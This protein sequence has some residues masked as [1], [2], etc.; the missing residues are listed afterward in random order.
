MDREISL[1]EMLDARERR[2]LR[3]RQL[4][5]AHRL[6][7]VSFTMN[8]A[9]PVKNGPVL[10]R[11]FREGLRRLEDALR[12]RRM[13]LSH[14]ELL[15]R[16]TGCEALLVVE[17]DAVSLKRLCAALEDRDALGRLFDIDVLGPDGEKL[18]RESLGFAPRPCLVCGREGKACASRRLHSLE[19]LQEK[20]GAILR[21]FFARKD[22]ETLAAQALRALLY[23]VCAA[24]KPA[25]VDRLNNGSHRDMDLFSFL[26][27]AASLLPY[28]RTAASLGMETAALSPEESFLRLREEGL[29][30]ERAMLAATGG[31][32]THKGAV[33]TLGTV[34]CAAGRLWKPERPWAET[35]A[36]LREAG[37]MSAR[38]A[39]LDL[40]APQA[41]EAET[42]GR[43][44]FRE[45]GIRGVR[46]ELAG[47]LPSVREIGLPAL[48]AALEAGAS[49]EQAGLAALA[50]LMAQVTDT[51]LLSR[52]GPEGQRWA[53]A[54]AERLSRPVPCLEEL[55]ALDREMTARGLSPGGCADLLALCYFLH[56]LSQLPPPGGA[57]DEISV[58]S[59]I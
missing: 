45:A 21:A 12:A 50:R 37:R 22:A 18:D 46:G 1:T 17:G 11:A 26:D 58:S 33:F 9:G 35:E 10:R 4:T 28:L 43:R 48:R 16:P 8:I 42:A 3:Q 14:L 39:G 47:G 7:L 56:F 44:F 51:N 55:A 59:S 31:V 53:A 15:D 23:E 40:T 49:L 20:T 2:A 52:G 38:E 57:L 5:Q 30:A 19:A 34:C 32:N 24:P 29:A 27:S 36:I 41:G 6:P 13:G 54:Q 25:L